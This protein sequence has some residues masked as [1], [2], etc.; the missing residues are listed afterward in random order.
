M[1]VE[2]FRFDVIIDPALSLK[3]LSPL[4][5]ALLGPFAL[6]DAFR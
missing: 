6:D 4:L 3:V 2:I 5:N 1:F